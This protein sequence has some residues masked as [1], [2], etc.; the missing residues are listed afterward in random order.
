MSAISP[1][2]YQ[3]HTGIERHSSLSYL[4]ASGVENL[5]VTPI[6]FSAELLFITLKKRAVWT[7]G[8]RSRREGAGEVGAEPSAWTVSRTL[9]WSCPTLRT[10]HHLCSSVI[11]NVP[12]HA[13]QPCSARDLVY[14]RWGIGL[15]DFPLIPN[16]VKWKKKKYIYQLRGNG[17]CYL[18][19]YHPFADTCTVRSSSKRRCSLL[20]FSHQ[21]GKPER[22]ACAGEGQGE[23]R[24][25]VR[26]MNRGRKGTG[27]KKAEKSQTEKEKTMCKNLTVLKIKWS[28]FLVSV[29]LLDQSGLLEVN[30]YPQS[31]H[32]RRRHKGKAQLPHT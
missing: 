10:H 31:F 17:G 11:K 22:T 19:P 29:H 5:V 26:L 21:I 9:V 4:P 14:R 8:H 12:L 6:C 28:A 23:R 7:R 18:K 16:Q 13:M 2:V 20:Y 32:A 15:F 1:A 30:E 27:K 24:E 25:R 3:H